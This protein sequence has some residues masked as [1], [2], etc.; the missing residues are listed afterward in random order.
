VLALVLAGDTEKVGATWTTARSNH[1]AAGNG[2]DNHGGGDSRR[3]TSIPS[4]SMFLSR[5][6]S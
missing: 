3:G 1:A 4:M 5:L 6:Q 2:E